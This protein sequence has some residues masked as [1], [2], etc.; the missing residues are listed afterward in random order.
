[1]VPTGKDQMPGLIA[2]TLILK[3]FAKNKIALIISVDE[4]RQHNSSCIHKQPRGHH[5]RGAGITDPRPVDV[6]SQEKHSYP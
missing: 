6:V 5:V 1:M 3:A 2:A 4:N